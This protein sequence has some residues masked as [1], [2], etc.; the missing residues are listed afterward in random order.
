[1]YIHGSVVAA[2]MGGVLT[3]D[4]TA[5][6]Q[7]MVSRPI[8]ASVVIGY[9][10]GDPVSGLVTGVLLELLWL[11]DLP[12]GAHVTTN[13]TALA[14]VA[15]SVAL[16]AG[17]HVGGV[18]PGLIV[19][20]ILLLLPLGWVFKKVDEAIRR[21]NSTLA[22]EAIAS[23]E[24]RGEMAINRAILKGVMAFFVPNVL[25]IWFSIFA[26]FIL[27]SALYPYTGRFEG[28]WDGIFYILP[29]V[30]IGS[31]VSSLRVERWL[32]VYILGYALFSILLLM[33]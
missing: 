30:G 22:D 11:G 20:V 4:R 33:R 15:T 25:L 8:V 18:R 27:V 7:V 14:V 1:M 13:E 16:L 21:F 29:L 12:V 31:V 23:F 26:G 24:D 17:P 28:L 10:L 5:V 32:P 3:L 9:L 19:F 2:L 6:L